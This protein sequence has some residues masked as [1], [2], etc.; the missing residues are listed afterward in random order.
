MSTPLLAESG[1]RRLSDSP[2]RGVVFRLRISPRIRSQKRNGSKD[3]VR[4]LWGSNFCKN[5]RKS[6][7]LPC[8]FK[9]LS[10]PCPGPHCKDKMPKILNKYSQKKNIG[11][12][13][14]ISTFMCLW[15]NYIFPRWVCLFCWRKYVRRLILGIYK[16]LKDTWMWKLGVRPRYSQ[17]RNI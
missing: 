3:T 4:D 11:A 2:S 10:S 5:P 17:K 8:P 9:S 16:S 14:P 15:A 7:S 1:S 13:V 12:S 6:A